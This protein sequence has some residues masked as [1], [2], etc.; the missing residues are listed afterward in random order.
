MELE[1]WKTGSMVEAGEK[2]YVAA[3]HIISALGNTTADNMEAIACYRSGIGRMADSALFANEFPAAPITSEVEEIEGFSRLES[4]FIAAIRSVLEQTGLHLSDSECMLV[5]ATTKGNIDRIDQ[6]DAYPGIMASRIAGYFSACHTPVVV[7]NACISGVSA[8]LVGA[9]LIESGKCKHVVV[10]GGDVL[11]RFVVTGFQSFKSVSGEAC[12]PYDKN[13][14]GLTLGEACGAVVLTTERDLVQSLPAVVIEGGGISNDA[15]H[16]S[17]PSRTGDGLYYAIRSAMS[18]AG[19]QAEDISFV[20]AHGT[21]TLYND[22]MEAKALNWAGLSST[23][24]NS[25]KGYWGHTLGAAGLIESIACF[26]QLR[27]GMVWGTKG[28]CEPGVSLHL[29]LSPFHRP[30]EMKCC[31]KTASGFG[32]CNVAAVFALEGYSRV[33]KRVKELGAKEVH[34]CQIRQGEVWVDE[35]RVCAGDSEFGDFIRL[36]FKTL[37][38]PNMKFY[39]MDDL[40]KLGYTAVAWLLREV[41]Y[42]GLT[43]GIV[44]GNR[45]SSLDTDRK[46]QEI[47]DR[48]GDA[49]ASPAVFVYTL[50]NVVMGE[51]CIRY[52][53]QGENTFFISKHKNLEFLRDYVCLLMAKQKL[54]SCIYGWC[55]LDGEYYEA[56]L[57]L[58]TI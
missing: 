14:D 33:R 31:L 11:S 30:V 48:L 1:K 23:P 21:A 46:H 53:I 43:T 20:N 13:R 50:P 38:Q 2:I 37:N 28:F 47:I 25:L 58:M 15:N 57:H 34:R 26:E 32:G 40:C 8:L 36:A 49:E 7:S 5:I 56:D 27:K 12:R 10:T 42:D 39:K 35:S 9:G 18:E 55:E 16:I 17:G 45:A 52:K 41:E 44:L 3:D 4:L 24:L 22:E 51:V 6:P 19:V 29:S 54:K